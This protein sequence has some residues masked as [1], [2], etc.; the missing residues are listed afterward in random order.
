M[1]FS[2]EEEEHLREFIARSRVWIDPFLMKDISDVDLVMKF[3]AEDGRIKVNGD[4]K[5]GVTD[6]IIFVVPALYS[7]SMNPE[8]EKIRSNGFVVE[9]AYDESSKK[10][11][12]SWID[13]HLS[14]RLSEVAFE[15]AK[16][17]REDDS[18]EKHSTIMWLKEFEA[19]AL[20][21]QQACKNF[22]DEMA[23]RDLAKKNDSTSFDIPDGIDRSMNPFDYAESLMKSSKYS[24]V[25]KKA[26]IMRYAK[27]YAIKQASIHH[28]ASIMLPEGIWN[29]RDENIDEFIWKG[30]V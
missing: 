24:E 10:D 8:L 15:R 6:E 25:E 30:C 12:N 4:I 5:W 28:C 20:N 27:A 9:E 1:S 14:R 21:N 11:L 19:K 26:R 16:Q 23:S 18:F 22:I 17:M 13:A 2:Y 29:F 3:E 7:V